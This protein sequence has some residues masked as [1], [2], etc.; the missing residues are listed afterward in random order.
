MAYNRKNH[1]IIVLFVQEFYKEQHDKGVPNTRI[2]E[3][4]KLHNIHISLATFYNYLAIPAVRDLKRI[5]QIRQQ[6]GV[7]F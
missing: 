5:E 6:Q 4:L 7:L 1:L 3:D 2:V